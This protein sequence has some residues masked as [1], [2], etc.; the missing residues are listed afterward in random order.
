MEADPRSLG[1][2]VRS[3]GDLG[4]GFIPHTRAPIDER[5][6]GK[7]MLEE[8]ALSGYVKVIYICKRLFVLFMECFSILNM[9][10]YCSLICIYYP[11]RVSFKLMSFSCFREIPVSFR[12]YIFFHAF[13]EQV[14]RVD[15]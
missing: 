8:I 12:L 11:F 4:P 3:V 6:N 10:F 13:S 7:P 5:E 9:S 1:A 2:R 15:A 14:G